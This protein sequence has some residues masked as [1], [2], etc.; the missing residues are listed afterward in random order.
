[1]KVIFLILWDHIDIYPNLEQN[2]FFE[3]VCLTP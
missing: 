1:M 2:V 3:V